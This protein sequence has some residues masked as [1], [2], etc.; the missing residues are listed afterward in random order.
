MKS[1][2][3]L[4]FALVAVGGVGVRSAAA[5]PTMIRL[6]YTGCAS[7]HLSPQGGGLLTTYGKG[8]DE[9]Q[10]LSA[11]EIEPS[12]TRQRRLLFDM[13]FLFA[14][15]VTQ[16]P[17]QPSSVSSSTFSAMLRGSVK[18][19]ERNR[20]SYVMGLDGPRSV[21]TIG[22]RTAKV[23]V[24]KALWEYRPKEGVEIAAGRDLMPSGIGLP[25]SQTFM[26][27]GVDARDAKYPTQVKAF[28][29]TERLQITPYVF[30]PGGDEPRAARQYGG[31]VLGGVDV[32]QHHAVLGLSTRATAGDEFN[33]RSVGAFARLGFGKWGV[34]AEHDLTS[35]EARD[36]IGV[37]T[38]TRHLAGHTQV[39][40]A[41][42]EWLVTSLAAE[43]LVIDGITRP[44]HTYRLTP[45]VQTRLSDNL[46][47]TFNM[48]DIF[49]DARSARS[50]TFTV[51]VAAKSVQ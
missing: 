7:C 20:M 10:S 4:L 38:D 41:P 44:T 3:V 2:Q 14:S 18:V 27:N 25:D 17:S 15:H 28:L 49:A 16:G 13:R 9:A 12:D 46:T 40:F 19:S 31:G 24:P 35:R 33:R 8:V 45:A 32:W 43:H 23:V 26:R 34:L 29:W 21:R 6:G 1:L 47:L 39:F 30:G 48:R 42:R 11:K 22:G 36:G 37:P 50:R 5:S 51:Q